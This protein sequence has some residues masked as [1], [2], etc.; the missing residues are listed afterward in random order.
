[1]A[2]ALLR[3]FRTSDTILYG[4]GQSDY[5]LALLSLMG[6]LSS[7]NIFVRCAQNLISLKTLTLGCGLIDP[8]GRL[9]DQPQKQKSG[10]HP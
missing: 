2:L 1:M 10:H 8:M 4:A 5:P 9:Y 3:A 6:N 7:C